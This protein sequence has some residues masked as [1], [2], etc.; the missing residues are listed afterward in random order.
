MESV[1]SGA[2]QMSYK[3]SS[4]LQVI[5][6]ATNLKHSS[7]NHLFNVRIT[8]AQL[9]THGA[10]RK[11]IPLLYVGTLREGNEEQELPDHP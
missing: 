8:E 5:L 10:S 2:G 9:W 6:I 11:D 1:I 7:H 4:E 3:S